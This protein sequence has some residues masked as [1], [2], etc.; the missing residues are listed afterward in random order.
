MRTRPPSFFLPKIWWYAEFYVILSENA[1]NMKKV[2]IALLA[3][4]LLTVPC[5]CKKEKKSDDIIATKYEV[6]RPKAPI[7]ME[8]KKDSKNVQWVG[9]SYTL[10][11]LRM[12]DDSLAYVQDETGQKFVDNRITLRI[13]RTDGSVFFQRTFVKQTFSSCL[14]DDYRKTGILEG[15]VL[16]KVDGSQ[17]VFA[18]SVCHPQTDE[19]I[20]LSIM[21]DNFGNVSV[22]RDDYMDTFGNEPKED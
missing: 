16:D 20:P 2:L 6:K 18:A 13:I 22:K 3:V 21:V 10:E 15:L 1:T 5:S 11:I 9:R 8:E 7:R 14:D 17:L 19:Y 12:P 4:G